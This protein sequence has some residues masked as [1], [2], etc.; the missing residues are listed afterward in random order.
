MPGRSR[1]DQIHATKRWHYPPGWQVVIV[2]GWAAEAQIGPAMA[3][4]VCCA[5]A[6][7]ILADALN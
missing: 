5:L 3:G 2:N 6:G 4:I 7:L 1:G